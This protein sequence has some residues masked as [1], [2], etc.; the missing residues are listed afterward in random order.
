MLANHRALVFIG[1][2]I[3][4]II[5]LSTIW[6]LL[7]PTYSSILA[8]TADAMT[9][10]GVRFHVEDG[11]ILVN[12]NDGS[13]QIS[14]GVHELSI[15]YGF[16]VAIA[17]IVATPGLNLLK[18]LKY[19]AFA[20]LAMFLVNV[21]AMLAMGEMAQ[22][23]SPAHPTIAGKP[24]FVFFISMGVDLFPIMIC[25]VLLFKHW[26]D[27]FSPNHHTEKRSDKK[28]LFTRGRK[29]FQTTQ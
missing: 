14:L 3:I 29:G 25:A 11:S 21:I 19:V 6:S 4:G 18:R 8:N 28:L 13:S 2:A 24:I 1:K 23:I 20:M 12:W 5:V 7:V 16:V 17:L 9:A 27:E 15:Q 26:L 10:D 22:S